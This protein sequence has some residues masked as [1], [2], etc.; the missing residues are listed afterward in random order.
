MT[1]TVADDD[2]TQEEPEEAEAAQEQ[3]TAVLD[4][5]VL[6]DVIQQL[7]A[8]TTEVIT[9]RLNTIASGSPPGAPLTLSL[10][11]VLADTVAF[12]YGEREHLRDGS[13]GW[14]QVFSRRSFALPLS[15]LNLA[16]G[17]EGLSTQEHPFSTLAI[18]GGG[19]DSSYR[20]IIENTDVDG[21]GFSAT[22]GMDLQ[23]T[24][25]LT[26]GLVLTTTRWGL[27]YAT[28]ANDANDATNASAE[29]TY[30]I[31]VTM[32]YPYVNWSATEHLSLWATLGYGRGEV[33]QDPEDG[34]ATTRSD[35]LTSWAGGVRFEV[36]PGM[37]P[38]TGQGAPFGLAIK[39]D[40]ATSSFLETSVQ[41]A[42][43]AAEVSRTFAVENGLLTTALELGWRLRS[44][45]DMDNPDPQQQ[46]IAEK[47]DGGG[48]E[49]AG[50]LN[51]L[52]TDGSVSAAV[53]PRVV[54]GGGHHREWGIGGHLRLAPSRQAGEGLSLTLQPSFGVT[55]TR[56]DELW[57]LSGD[58]DPA[59]NNDP[60]DARLDAKL[61]YGFPLGD[62][63]L[64]PYTEVTWAE[65]GST[66]GAGL[67]YGL[68]TSLELDLKGAR[69]H[70][71]D[72]NTESCFLLD[73]RSRL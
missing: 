62:A 60:P 67:R 14:R 73:M 36:V 46:A 27:D 64:T 12:L 8:Q 22:I 51:W 59:I 26:T 5:V 29:G 42:R 11:D 56:L 10:D 61:A 24:P 53:E 20:N 52:N 35:G 6:P 48:A 1:V 32:V 50:R 65:G 37:D 45:S 68:N 41:L 18:W 25:Q 40:G 13:L 70:H 3:A 17:E 9:S 54:L 44:V 15:S 30:E 38:R 2:T 55:G 43:L 16:Q 28:D 57:S 71:A 63:L 66:Y 7:A 33:E 39:A 34:K 21:N 4:E 31:G 49:L 23:P 47:N 69:H 19:N 72:G 58:G